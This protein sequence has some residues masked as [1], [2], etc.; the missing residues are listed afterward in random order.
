VRMAIANANALAVDALG[1]R[2]AMVDLADDLND[3]EEHMA[4]GFQ[5]DDSY[6]VRKCIFSSLVV[7]A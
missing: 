2:S 5:D 4:E 1:G 7:G 6:Q 3:D